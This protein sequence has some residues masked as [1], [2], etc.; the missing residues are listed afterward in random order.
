MTESLRERRER[1]FQN[2]VLKAI[3][4]ERPKTNR[5]LSLIN[6]RLFAAVVLGSFAAVIGGYFTHYQQCISDAERIG[7]AW[8]RRTR[9]AMTRQESL[10][11]AIKNAQTLDEIRSFKAPLVY[12]ELKDKSL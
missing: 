3:E 12:S 8:S 7:E 11:L 6:S 9:E 2:R 10:A 4:K 5:F 1:E